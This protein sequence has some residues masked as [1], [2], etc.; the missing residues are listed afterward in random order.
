MFA[1]EKPSC[2]RTPRLAGKTLSQANFRERYGLNVLSIWRAGAPLYGML[3]E[4]PLQFGDTLLIQGSPLNM[5]RMHNEQDFVLLEEDPDAI[6][7]PGKPGWQRR[8]R[9]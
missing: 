4:L 7:I 8:S 3:A 2:R 6:L 1:W 9:C 5:R